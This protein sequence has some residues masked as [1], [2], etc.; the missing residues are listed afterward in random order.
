[1]QSGGK[2]FLVG[3]GPGHPE[4][5]TVKGLQLLQQADVVVFDRLVQEELLAACRPEAERIY[6]GKAPGRHESR[7]GEIDELLVRL[8]RRGGLVVRLKGGDPLLFGRGGEEAEALARAGVPFEII[9]G[10]TA[11]LAA[12][13]AA[14]IPV[15]HRQHACSFAVVTGHEKDGAGDGRVDW[16]ALARIDTLVVLMGVHRL[17]HIARALV[18]HGRAP[19]TPAAIVETAFWAGERVVEG[20][21]ATI[22]A[23][24]AAAGVRPPATLVVGEV[25]GCRAVLGAQA[26]DLARSASAEQAAPGP[27]PA[28]LAAITLGLR[29][30]RQLAAALELRLFDA[31]EAPCTPAQLAAARGLDPEAV[32]ELC[33]GLVR[34]RL[35]I[36]RGAEVRNVEMA[37]RYLRSDSAAYVGEALKA[38]LAAEL[39][40]DPLARL[41]PRPRVTDLS[42]VRV[43]PQPCAG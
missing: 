11:A 3:A 16:G 26:R 27:S 33:D 6:V 8:G 31:L 41:R 21:L 19:T 9:P 32:A 4:L 23:R 37:S 34:A 18:D 40:F 43:P 1:M 35:L 20:T 22:A 15:T 29:H 13:A 12:P 36:R 25:V 42:T 30:A 39:A 38:E 14:G 2:V 17:E 5:I 7:Q 10:V 28:G 24:A